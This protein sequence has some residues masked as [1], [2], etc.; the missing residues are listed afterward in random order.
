MKKGIARNVIVFGI[1]TLF[2]EASIVSGINIQI[3]ETI[4]SRGDTLYVGGSGEGNYT[5]IQDAINN[6]SDGDTVFVYNGTYDEHLIINV[7]INLIGESTHNTIVTRNASLA[8]ITI[9]SDHVK[10]QGFTISSKSPRSRTEYGIEI[11]SSYCNISYC[12]LIY[13]SYEDIRIFGFSNH[14]NI[15]RNIF[16]SAYFGIGFENCFSCSNTIKHNN[17]IS[18]RSPTDGISFRN[19]W[20]SNYYDNWIGIGPKII[21]GLFFPY[22]LFWINID[23]RPS[24][25]PYD[26]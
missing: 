9:S 26:I 13:N 17:F 5:R 24:K 1:I 12:K 16:Q 20:V 7:R 14:N 8:V 10:V 22:P 4:S 19:H 3:E 21:S 6:A 23:W 18:D 2:I 11:S 25:V 15:Y